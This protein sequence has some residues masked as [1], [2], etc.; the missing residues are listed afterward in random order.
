L[1]TIFSKDDNE[2]ES[3]N[4]DDD[5]IRI[6]LN[7]SL[8]LFLLVSLFASE[9]SVVSINFFVP[10]VFVF[11]IVLVVFLFDVVVVVFD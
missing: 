3:D 2:S 8:I 9:L 5:D 1:G 11:A 10:A 6:F 7:V 4:V